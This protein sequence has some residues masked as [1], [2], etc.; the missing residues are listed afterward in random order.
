MKMDGLKLTSISIDKIRPCTIQAPLRESG[1]RLSALL[2]AIR[3]DG[4]ILCPVAVVPAG[5]GIFTAGD[6]HRRIHCARVLGMT[7]VPAV[8]HDYGITA[9][10]L[11]ILLNRLT[12]RVTGP[13]WLCA[14]AFADDE[15][16]LEMEKAA[17]NRCSRISSMRKIANVH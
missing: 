17:P 15:T 14:W 6:G 3:L 10:A 4:R 7:E 8:I 13:D 2:E 1:R 16:R 9:E 11:F 12:P 5:N